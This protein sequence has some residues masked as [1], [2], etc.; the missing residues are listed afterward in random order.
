MDEQCHK[1][2]EDGNVNEEKVD[3]ILRNG[4]LWHGYRHNECGWWGHIPVGKT[5]TGVTDK[6][7]KM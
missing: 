3:Y 2:Q 4:K 5:V 6:Y 7:N 1:C